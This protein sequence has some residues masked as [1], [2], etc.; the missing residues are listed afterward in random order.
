MRDR[1]GQIIRKVPCRIRA[2]VHELKPQLACKGARKSMEQG[3]ELQEQRQKQELGQASGDRACSLA[4]RTCV[5]K[6][7][8]CCCELGPVADGTRF[9]IGM[10]R[11]THDDRQGARVLSVGRTVLSTLMPTCA[12]HFEPLPS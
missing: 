6:I 7:L 10:G 2:G 3:C 9:A 8:G 11:C 12:A 1:A 4:R 5:C